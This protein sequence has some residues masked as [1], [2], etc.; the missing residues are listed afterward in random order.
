MFTVLNSYKDSNGIVL[1]AVRDF[2]SGA[3]LEVIS[4]N[5]LKL[6]IGMDLQMKDINDNIVRLQGG[7]L[8]L[9]VEDITDALNVDDE[10]DEDE[11]D[12]F[13][14]AYE[15]E[16]E[17]EVEEEIEEESFGEYEDDEEDDFFALYEEDEEPEGSVVSKLYEKLIEDQIKILKRYYL[18]YSQRLF[19]DAQKDPTL[20]LTNKKKIVAK[21]SA[22]S[23]LRGD[24]DWR[25][26]GFLDTGSVMA[27]YTCTL[28]HALRYMHLAWDITVGDIE[29]CFF[30]E[31]YNVDFE[32][33][34]M[35][36]NCIVYGI[37]CIG[38]FFEVDKECIGNLQRAQRE[39]L[40]DMAI[41]YEFYSNNSIAEAS[42]TFKLLDE[43]IATISKK[44]MK[45]KMLRKDYTPILPFSMSAF[46]TQ[47]RENNMIPPKSLV[48]N[49]RSC[50]VGW[51]S[52]ERYFNNKWTGELKYPNKYLFENVLPVVCKGGSFSDFSAVSIRGGYIYSF[53]DLVI[54]YIYV[55]FAY[56]LCGAYKYDADT[57]KD[58]GGK[59]KPVRAKLEM[60]YR[61]NTSCLFE[62]LDFSINTLNILL[63]LIEVLAVFDN[64]D[65]FPVEY[66]EKYNLEKPVTTSM[67]HIRDSIVLDF[68]KE[69]GSN[70]F[71]MM[72]FF[73]DI[74]GQFK[75]GS[76]KRRSSFISKIYSTSG[77]QFSLRE[78][79]PLIQEKYS[80]LLVLYENF[81][82][83]LKDRDSKLIADHLAEEEEKRRLEEESKA[84]E[85][86]KQEEQSKLANEVDT[87]LKVVDYLSK[88]DALDS[89]DS[90][91]DLP[92]SILSTVLKS[93]KEPSDRQ[94][95][96]LSRLYKQVAGV[97]YSG[98]GGQQSSKIELSSRPDLREA[99]S[100]ILDDDRLLDDCVVHLKGTTAGAV[101]F[102][103][104][105]ES[106]IR[107]GK[108]SERQLAYAEA[109]KVVFDEKSTEEV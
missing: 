97:D 15:E 13:F 39:S 6:L 83:Y 73:R 45:G 106:I 52:G 78:V 38:D 31:D 9:D 44:D 40:R 84:K 59:S 43:I 64:K 46:Y 26:A 72:E 107:Y 88:S 80:E 57:N 61:Q 105:L 109:A 108:I 66:L 8:V 5:D 17:E 53:K 36:N 99:I 85:Q 70:A 21:K 27:G 18:W 94:F 63:K 92:K 93:G 33:I 89:L 86:A 19:N 58:E 71:D 68:D 42:D 76:S 29:T 50:L 79:Y 48:Q 2:S 54:N 67:L 10:E 75:R 81:T 100:F 24:G 28:G 20:G 1:Y 51:T 32:S 98:V 47:F 77:V 11:V 55:L 69:T 37:K 62:D 56:E 30:G 103:S 16:G 49:I 90:E 3:D 25:Y 23:N 4:E 35:S 96:H 102:K 101:K 14:G 60:H 95:Y 34:I 12:D 104:V 65:A 22:L 87:P 91:W 7:S 82:R 41:L 74:S